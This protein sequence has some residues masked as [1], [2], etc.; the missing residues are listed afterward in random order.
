MRLE[1][2]LSE[3]GFFPKILKENIKVFRKGKIKDTLTN[4]RVAR[5]DIN[6]L[7]DF[8]LTISH[9]NFSPKKL[10]LD[11]MTRL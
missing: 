6:P 1:K 2:I 3:I 8:I 5:I 4:N 9:D 11:N 7:S 10:I